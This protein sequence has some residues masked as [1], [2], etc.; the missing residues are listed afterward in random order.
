MDIEENGD[1]YEKVAQAI[2]A[3]PY[4][5]AADE[6]GRWVS[7]QVRR[8][9][10]EG[11]IFMYQPGCNYQS[12][13]AR[14]VSDIVEGETGT[15]AMILERS[16]MSQCPCMATRGPLRNRIEAFIEMLQ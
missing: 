1:P 14:I 8:S 4:E 3:S 5:M 15:S 11:L 6:R 9:R 16:P 2:I 7:D 10:A 12:A 13:A